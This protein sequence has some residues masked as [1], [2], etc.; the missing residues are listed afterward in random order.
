MKN[1]EL[2]TDNNLLQYL[3]EFKKAGYVSKFVGSKTDFVI[4]KPHYALYASVPE[5]VLSESQAS[6]KAFH[7]TW[8]PKV[9]LENGRLHPIISSFVSENIP[10]SLQGFENVIHENIDKDLDLFLQNEYV[11]I[12]NISEY[13]KQIL[14]DIVFVPKGSLAK[15]NTLTQN[16]SSQIFKKRPHDFIPE[17]HFKLGTKL[18][19]FI[20]VS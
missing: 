14:T 7:K 10:Y 11:F 1:H 5:S 2:S 20:L 19:V 16:R 18:D 3:Q 13:I 15:F 6:K 9:H 4:G 8:S 12:E 17:R